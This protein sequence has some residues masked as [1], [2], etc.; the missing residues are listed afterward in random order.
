MKVTGLHITKLRRILY[1][2]WRRL[3]RRAYLANP[4]VDKGLRH[5]LLCRLFLEDLARVNKDVFFIQIGA[6]DGVTSD[7]LHDTIV[8]RKWKGILIEPVR[9]IF[10]TLVEN[11]KGVPNLIFENIAIADCDGERTFYALKPEIRKKYPFWSDMLGSFDRT[12]ILKSKTDIPDIEDYIVAQTVTCLSFS[13][14][15]NKHNINAFDVLLIDVEGYDFE[16]LKQVD[17]PRY[18]P[19]II[20]L[21]H[22]HLS[23]QDKINAKH[24][25]KNAGYRVNKTECDYI[26]RLN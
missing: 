12:V 14:L 18:K 5:Y 17:L 22:V 15:L 9:E 10:E 2:K 4:L 25:V 1:S 24:Y 16:V 13:S 6:H 3:K 11:K 8:N 23:K 20:I 7:F 26:A 19:K 21:E